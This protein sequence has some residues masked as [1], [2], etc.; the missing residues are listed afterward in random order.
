[1]QSGSH[2]FTE[3]RQ[4]GCCCCSPF[5]DAVRF[6]V[7]LY[8]RLSITCVAQSTTANNGIKQNTVVDI[9]TIF[10]G[11]VDSTVLSCS[12]TI[13]VFKFCL[14]VDPNQIIMDLHNRD[15]IIAL[16]TVDESA[17]AEG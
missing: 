6:A 3:A 9:E 16:C 7:D 4:G 11:Q 17:A 5:F 14:V 8:A 10:G 1:M 13:A 12:N 15:L 2:L